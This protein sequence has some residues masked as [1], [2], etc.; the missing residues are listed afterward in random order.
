MAMN[1]TTGGEEETKVIVRKFGDNDFSKLSYEVVIGTVKIPQAPVPSD[2]RSLCGL[3]VGE[4]RARKL[5]GR[6][7]LEMTRDSTDTAH[8]GSNR[9]FS[10]ISPGIVDSIGTADVVLARHARRYAKEVSEFMGLEIRDLTRESK[11]AV[12]AGGCSEMASA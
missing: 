6:Y 7:Y 2:Y 4:A 12:K 9:R 3:C 11:L 1:G 5:N 8:E 10:E